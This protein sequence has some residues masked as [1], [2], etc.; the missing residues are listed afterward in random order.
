MKIP[1]QLSTNWENFQFHLKN[2]P[3][4]IP[5]SPSNEHLDVA[6]G[7]LGDLKIDPILDFI[8][9]QSTKCFDRLHQI[10]NQSIR[11]IPAC[12]N[13]VPSFAK[14]LRTALHHIYQHFPV[15]KRLRRS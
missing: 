1:E 6:F 2:K 12:D 5:E 4:P 7:R 15:L 3:L 10:P 14:R 13:L 11:V 9:D 8:K